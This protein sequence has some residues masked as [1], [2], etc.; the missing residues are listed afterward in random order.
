MSV[1]RLEDGG[2]VVNVDP[3]LTKPDYS[4]TLPRTTLKGQGDIADQVFPQ[5]MPLKNRN[6]PPTTAPGI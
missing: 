1:G 3:I 6:K 5:A 2:V 4:A